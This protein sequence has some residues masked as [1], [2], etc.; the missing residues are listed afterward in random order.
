MDISHIAHPSAHGRAQAHFPE[1]LPD[2]AEAVDYRSDAVKELPVVSI[3]FKERPLALLMSSILDKINQYLAPE[4]GD[5][6]IQNAYDAGIDISPEATADR[7]VSLSTGF[8]EAFKQQHEDED[9]SEV[10][11]KFMDTIGKGIEQGF[12]EAR[13]ILDSLGALEGDIASNI[14]KTYDLVQQGLTNFKAQFED[15]QQA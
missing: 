13:E 15:T 11:Q 14:D 1:K 4:M 2:H 8:F 6:A 7:I 3:G 12:T 9:E 10:L 5:N